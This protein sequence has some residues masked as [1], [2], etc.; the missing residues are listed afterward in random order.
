MTENISPQF[1]D[2]N[3]LIYS[4]DTQGGE[5]FEVTNRLLQ[6][7]WTQENGCI[8]MQV[9]QEFYVNITRKTR[10]PL[11]M[12]AARQAVL[13]FCQWTVHR[14]AVEDVLAAI[15]IQQRFLGDAVFED[16]FDQ[17]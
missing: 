6:S 11:S 14:P 15:D 5:K 10:K 13:D 3:I 1:V 2:T 8:S 9:L 4:Y 12:E 16:R 7:L 17:A